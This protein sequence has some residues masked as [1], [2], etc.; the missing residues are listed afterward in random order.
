MAY[1]SVEYF[2]NSK[3]GRVVPANPALRD[4]AAT[5]N[6][7]KPCDADGNLLRDDGAASDE[8]T[9]LREEL[10]NTQTELEILKAEL[11]EAR[12][13]TETETP[14]NPEPEPQDGDGP[15]KI[16]LLVQ[17]IGELEDGNP[18]HF[19]TTGE[20]RVEVLEAFSG[21]DEVSSKERDEAWDRYNA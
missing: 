7:L 9:K 10:T 12:G 3:T 19:T 16:D 17:A 8:V 13:E 18:D 1:E 14:D 15:T 11:R 4:Y 5:K 20:P 21:F 2:F 6:H